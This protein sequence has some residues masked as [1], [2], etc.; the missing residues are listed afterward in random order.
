MYVDEA[1]ITIESGKGGNGCTSFRRE[2]F[3]AAGGPDGGDGGKGGDIIFETEQ[4]MTTLYYFRHHRIFKAEKGGDGGGKNCHGKDADDLIIRVPIGT[5]LREAES[6]LVVADLSKP[7]MH[8]IILKG[9]RGGKGNQHYATATMQIPQYSQSGRPGH[10]LDLI[11]ELKVLADVGLLGYPNAGKSTF[12]SRVSNAKPKIADY[13]FTTLEPN[14]G[15]V[16]LSYGKS[17]VIADIPGLIEGAADGAGL[18]HEFLKHLERTRVLI[19][20]VDTAGL[21]GRDPISDLEVIN[22]ELSRYSAE[23]ASLPQIIAANKMDLPDAQAFY[24]ELEQYCNEK[25]YEVFPISAATGKG[26]Q[27]LLDRVIQVRD[28]IAP[29]PRVFDKEFDINT[30]NQDNGLSEDGG[31]TIDLMPDG[32][33]N[34]GGPAI[35]KMLGYTYLDTEKGFDFFQ[36]FL[37]E[38]GVIDRLEAMGI[39]EGDTVIVADIAFEFYP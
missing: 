38:R 15:V 31:I 17:M 26:I 19:H 27:A 12:L 6:G 21:D 35:E 14:L 25:G 29:E 1:R 33:Y 37:R 20:L 8:E 23:L 36:R 34:I 11:L 24:P 9:G 32:A 28:S 16:N 5:V 2:K 3:V 4:G 39:Q 13:P 22:A 10:T 18:G 30:L 7:D